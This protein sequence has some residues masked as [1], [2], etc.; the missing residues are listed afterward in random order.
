MKK[1]L[2]IILALI[3]SIGLFSGCNTQTAN[4]NNESKNEENNT[5]LIKLATDIGKENTKISQAILEIIGK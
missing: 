5:K 4:K 2:S 1:T 3:L